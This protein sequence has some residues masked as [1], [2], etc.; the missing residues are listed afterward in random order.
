MRKPLPVFIVNFYN[1]RGDV[2]NSFLRRN[3]T[4]TQT[5]QNTFSNLLKTQ[6]K[7]FKKNI[8]F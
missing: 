1:K 8:P 5:Q 3:M 4:E 7:N 2:K 6:K